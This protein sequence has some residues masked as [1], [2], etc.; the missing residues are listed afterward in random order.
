[1]IDSVEIFLCVLISYLAGSVSPAFLAGMFLKRIDLRYVGSGT[2]GAS[3]VYHHVGKVWVLPVMLFDVVIKGAGP[4]V[5]GTRLFDLSLAGQVLVG[6]VAILGH[7][8]PIFYKFKGGRG[9]A[10]IVGVLAVL[11]GTELL[12]FIVVGL[13]LWRLT[14]SAGIGVLLPILVLPLL[15]YG[16]SRPVEIVSLM[17]GI[18]LLTIIKR[19]AANALPA[20]GDRVGIL[21]NRLIF[22]RD[23]KDRDA[24][25]SNVLSEK[26]DEDSE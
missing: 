23:I 11:A 18:V 12:I 24:W 14:K 9:V 8:W 26:R 17:L 15:S 5:L 21:F 20:K 19:L 13:A 4:I 22:D 2:L 6:L 7:N 25:V 1:M 10:P 3:N 16:L